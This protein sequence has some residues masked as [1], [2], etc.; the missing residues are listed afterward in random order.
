[1]SLSQSE[2]TFLHESIILE[3]VIQRK[4]LSTK[5]EAEIDSF[6]GQYYPHVQAIFIH[7]IELFFTLQIQQVILFFIKCF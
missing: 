3:I 7:Y 5:D 6:Y 2:S 1:M 4:P